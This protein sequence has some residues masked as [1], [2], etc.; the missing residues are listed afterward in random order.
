MDT[1]DFG[2]RLRAERK[3]RRLTLQ[4]LAGK[5]EISSGLLSQIERGQT[6]PSLKTLLKLRNTLELP[7]SFFFEGETLPQPDADPA[8]ICRAEDRPQLDLGPG[9]PHKELLHHGGSRI[10]EMMIVHTPPKGQL[11]PAAVQYPSE[12]GGVVLEGSIE[13]RVGE[14]ASLLSIGD[15]FLFDGGHAH[16]LYNPT[17]KP[18]RILW[19]IAR[20]PNFS[21]F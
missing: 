19:I 21:P 13:L 2:E 4:E 18:A 16:S 6:S 3:A 15:S 1:Q 5:T 12:K 7:S 11:G 9:A 14:R 8:Y 17:D 20:L 10:F